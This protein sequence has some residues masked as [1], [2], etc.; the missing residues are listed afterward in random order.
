MSTDIY[1][2]IEVR[3]PLWDQDWF[4][5]D[6]WSVACPL[7]PLL[8]ENDYDAF[9]CL[10]GVRNYAGWQPIAPARGIPVDASATVREDFATFLHEDHGAS[11]ITW[12]ELA[13]LDMTVSP[14]GVHGQLT[15]TE[16][17]LQRT[18]R[19]RGSWPAEILDRFGRLPWGSTPGASYGVIQAEAALLAY[20]PLTRAAVLG[21]GT[22]WEHVF[23]VMRALAGRF[24]GDGVRLV[25][26]FD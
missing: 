23:A 24:G 3:D 21:P 17:C 16:A 5:W 14:E 25:A 7:H 6:P 18:W 9:A 1:G 19:P 22:G 26:Y 20:Q 11:W 15:L 2:S 12:S 8:A 4:D 10:F 13:D